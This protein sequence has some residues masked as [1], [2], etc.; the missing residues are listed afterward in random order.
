MNFAHKEIDDTESLGNLNVPALIYEDTLYEEL[1]D[2]ED[3][4]HVYLMEEGRIPPQNSNSMVEC[5]ECGIWMKS[6]S[7]YRHVKRIHQKLRRFACDFCGKSFFTKNE[8]LAHFFKCH[9]EKGNMVDPRNEPT[10]CPECGK[11]VAKQSIRTHI[12][13]V[14]RKKTICICDFC[15]KEFDRKICLIRHIATH[16]PKEFR[17]RSEKCKNCGAC[18]YNKEQ[19]RKHD[20][21]YGSK[22]YESQTL[23]CAKVFKYLKDKVRN[24]TKLLC[25]DCGKQFDKL[26]RLNFHKKIHSEPKFMCDE[27]GCGK[28]FYTTTKKREH[29]NTV[30][31]QLRNFICSVKDCGKALST[32]QGLK[33]HVKVTHEQ[34]KASCPVDGCSFRVGRRQYMRDHMKKHTELKAESITALLQI[35]KFMKSLFD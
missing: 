13:F 31:L 28:K 14:H 10:P 6:A 20:R 34:V 5:K 22:K 15:G 26:S 16:I 2:S 21:K 33:R 11:V 4:E 17:E 29:I 18:F 23:E 27:P 8:I 9:N 3:S 35:V 12:K 25:D 7:I 1:Q 32:K 19:L 30:H 24:Q